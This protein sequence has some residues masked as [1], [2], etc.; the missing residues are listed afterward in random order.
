MTVRLTMA[1]PCEGSPAQRAGFRPGDVILQVNGKSTEGLTLDQ[2]VSQVLGAA[3]TT[4]RLTIVTPST[5]QTREV[6]ILRAHIVLHEVTW[7]TLPGTT[8]ADARI[9]EFSNGVNRDLQ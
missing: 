9:S 2:V 5:N 7:R 3:G 6:S 4:V 8:L 1:T